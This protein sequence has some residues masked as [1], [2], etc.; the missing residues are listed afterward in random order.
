MFVFSR[1]SLAVW[2]LVAAPVV[3]V[4]CGDGGDA[5]T[6]P[7]HGVVLLDG[8][9]LDQAAVAFIGKGGARLA[10]ASTDS[11]GKFSLNAS[12]GK[13]QVTVS[14]DAP[15][16]AVADTGDGLMPTD[17]EF[18]KLPP[19]PKAGVPAKYADPKTSGLTINVV[20]GMEQIEL[21]LNSK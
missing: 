11:A 14:K 18:A 9:P 19:P 21:S 2:A 8:Q 12:L 6:V 15:A 7:V 4:G 1:R 10:S 3:L 16:A 17:A 20:D 5:G 13:N